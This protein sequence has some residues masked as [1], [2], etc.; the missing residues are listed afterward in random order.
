M[1]ADT[2]AGS[3]TVTSCFSAATLSLVT[4]HRGI[5]TTHGG[6]VSSF[7]AGLALLHQVLWARGPLDISQAFAPRR[8]GHQPQ[9]GK[10]S[11]HQQVLAG[12][13]AQRACQ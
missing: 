10:G 11:R 2:R 7:T 3:K 12:S 8:G 9:E 5:E 4:H 13:R 1:K 6:K